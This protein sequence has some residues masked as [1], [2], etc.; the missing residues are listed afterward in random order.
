MISVQWN[1]S[2]VATV[3]TKDFGHYRGVATN[4]EFYKY[5][6]NAVGTKVSGHYREGGLSSGVAIKRGSTV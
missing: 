4:Q 1:P 6:F 5:H 3:G 2:V